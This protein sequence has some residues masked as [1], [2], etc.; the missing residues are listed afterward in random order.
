MLSPRAIPVVFAVIGAGG[1]V[2]LA[3][4]EAP[5]T[6]GGPRDRPEVLADTRNRRF[7][8]RLAAS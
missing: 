4:V 5:A 1:S 2:G 6:P 3:A 8:A 7:L